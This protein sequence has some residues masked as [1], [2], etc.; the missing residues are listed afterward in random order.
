MTEQADLSHWELNKAL[1][2]S[3]AAVLWTGEDPTQPEACS[4]R[5]K[6][7]L[8]AMMEAIES[9]HL[10]ANIEW[11]QDA[12]SIDVATPDWPTT[13]VERAELAKWARSQ[14][15][16]PRFLESALKKLVAGPPQATEP[17]QPKAKTKPPVQRGYLTPEQVAEMT[18]FEVGTLAKWRSTKRHPELKWSKAAGRIRY[19]EDDVRA[20]IETNQS[21]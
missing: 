21:H 16:A 10:K 12:A 5:Y 14:G 1:S 2:L 8:Q 4:N 20:F 3:D 11:N 19:K 18:G 17:E 9:G 13:T 7:V 6:P 15:Q